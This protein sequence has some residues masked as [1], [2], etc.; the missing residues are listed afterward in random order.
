MNRLAPFVCA[1]LVGCA[2]HSIEHFSTYRDRLS[3]LDV[4]KT[5]QTAARSQQKD[6]FLAAQEESTRRGMDGP[7]CQAKI[8]AFDRNMSLIIIGAGV[9]ATAAASSG[10]GGFAPVTDYDW[11]W[12]EF[13]NDQFQLAWACRGRQTGEFA[14]QWRCSGKPQIDHTWPGK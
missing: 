10:G 11:A 8:E 14:D 7:A 13:Y 3:D 6:L 12:D 9:A 4:C 5:W 1:A 2:S